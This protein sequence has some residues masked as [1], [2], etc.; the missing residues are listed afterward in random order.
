MLV[1]LSGIVTLV[2]LLQYRKARSPMLV[3]LSG[4]VTLVKLL[5]PEKAEPP[6]LVTGF[7]A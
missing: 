2:R 3:T 5:Q 1:T 7:P 4:I 6:M